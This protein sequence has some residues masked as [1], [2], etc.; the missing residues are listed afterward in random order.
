MT[1]T[2]LETISRNTGFSVSTVSRVLNDKGHQSRISKKTIEIIA[3]EAN[4]LGYA[5]NLVAI[6]LRTSKTH[7]IGLIVP[8]LSNSYF[9]EMA[10]VIISEANK[11]GYTTV[12]TD[13]MESE[14]SQDSAI[15]TMIS[16]EVDGIIIAPCGEDPR[17]LEQ[18]NE[19]YSPI[20]LIDRYYESSPLSY[21]VTNNLHGGYMATKYLLQ[22]GHRHIACI[23]GTHNTSPNKKRVEG[24]LKAL[25]EYDI[26]DNQYI[27]GN[28]FSVQN[29]YLETKLI[30]NRKNRP[31]AIFAL[32]N[33]I[34]LGAIKA[35]REAG[36]NIPDDI[37]IISFDNNIY[38]DYLTPPITRVEQKV[39]VMGKLAMKLLNDTIQDHISV[40]SQ[41]EISTNILVRESVAPMIG[42]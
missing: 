7:T 2:T 10:S 3:N 32:S 36:L 18:T 14:E 23:Q 5:Q 12:V 24:Y 29:G 27:V 4:R 11:L 34:C 13:T 42:L 31:T 21:V 30:L 39:D 40:N 35:I 16:K 1:K 26:L 37:S 38:L 22:N 20:M 9:A 33:N 41:I 25:K 17:Y 15:S 28:E 19:Q 6:K 8:S